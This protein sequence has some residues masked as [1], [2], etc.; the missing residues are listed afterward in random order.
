MSD[1]KE[2]IRKIKNS[3]SYGK[4]RHDIVRKLQ[5]KG[6]KLEYIDHL[7]SRSTKAKKLTIIS[8]LA[9]VVLISIA[10]TFYYTDFPTFTGQVLK[11][12]FEDTNYVPQNQE[13]I[14]TLKITPDLITQLLQEI[15]ADKLHK[16]PITRKPAIIVFS[17]SG[18]VYYSEID[19]Q[20]KTFE[21]KLPQNKFADLEITTTQLEVQNALL[22]QHP[23]ENFKSSLDNGKTSINIVANK[24]DLIAKGYSN[25]YENLS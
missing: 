18:K 24:L 4:S 5:D 17:I 21:S 11:T 13:Q 15:N 9:L 19:K 23:K 2:I 16:N 8:L 14:R 12:N 3:L 20:I 22:N 7:I 10:S 1:E 25:I 6:Y